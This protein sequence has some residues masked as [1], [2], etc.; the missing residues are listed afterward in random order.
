[1]RTKSFD[2]PA[3]YGDHHVSD[4]RR[5]LLG[6]PGVKDV[7]ASSAFHIVEVVYD[8]NI[9]T[10]LSIQSKLGDAGYLGDWAFQA[11]AGKAVGT[12]GGGTFMR[13]TAVYEQTKKV[14]SFTQNVGF[15]GRPLWPC[16][17]MGPIK[18][19]AEEK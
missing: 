19:I 17:G 7:Y 2:V 11:E 14:V 1:M 3:M 4:V 15:Q 16:P 10:D 9:S 13:H 12:D 5:I 6:I 8:E 18:S